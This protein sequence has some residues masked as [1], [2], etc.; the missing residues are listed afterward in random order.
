MKFALSQKT[1]LPVILLIYLAVA[2]AQYLSKDDTLE[3]DFRFAPSPVK[4]VASG[5][6]FKGEKCEYFDGIK[7]EPEETNRLVK[8]GDEI[9]RYSIYSYPYEDGFKRYR[10]KEKTCT[11]YPLGD[12]AE[13]NGWFKRDKDDSIGMLDGTTALRNIGGK[14]WM[15]SYAVGILV[16]DPK[17]GKFSR[18]DTQ[19]E[20]KGRNRL[21]IY[22]ADDDYLFAGITIYSFKRKTW[23]QMI[24]A[25]RRAFAQFGYTPEAIRQSV[26]VSVDHRPYASQ[27]FI[28]LEWT[29]L[30]DTVSVSDDGETYIFERSFGSFDDSKTIYKI[31]KTELEKFFN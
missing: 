25:P 5:I 2:P 29:F 1:I 20:T 22:Y 4:L 8:I 17:T 30:P 12:L 7:N 24:S 3:A 21:H 23:R 9:F 11:D 6:N 16:F 15:G 13:L 19:L 28:T 14:L 26:Q 18:H 27:P 31:T 10:T